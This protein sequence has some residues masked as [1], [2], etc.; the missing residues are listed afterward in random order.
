MRTIVDSPGIQFY[1][2]DLCEGDSSHSNVSRVF[3]LGDK[4]ICNICVEQLK[5]ILKETEYENN[6]SD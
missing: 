4:G 5:N 2:C 3:S 6:D 1:V